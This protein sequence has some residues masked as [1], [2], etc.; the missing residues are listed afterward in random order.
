MALSCDG[1]VG[2]K[3]RIGTISFDRHGKPIPTENKPKAIFARLFKVDSSSKQAQRKQLAHKGKMI[4]MV[5]ENAND[6]KRQLGKSDKEKLEEYMNSISDIEDRVNRADKWLDIP[7]K[8]VNTDHIK[9]DVDP[10][11]AP[12]EYYRTMYDLIALAFE[13]DVTRA[14]TFMM[15][16]EDG[17]GI[18]DAF[19]T[20]SQGLNGHHKLSHSAKEKDGY[21]KWSM[22][23]QF[24]ANQVAYFANRLNKIK[25]SNGTVLDNTIVFFGSGC[26]TTHAANN[27]PLL[28]C[29]GN[30]MGFKHGEHRKLDKVRLSNL[31]LTQLKAMG[32]EIDSFADST[33]VISGL[34]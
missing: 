11:K 8:K 4:D 21:K 34:I 27:Y 24:V 22:H 23:D 26:S 32:I 33:G 12:E 6:L 17:M 2:F 18:A 19:S 5:M 31:Y 28:M 30:N 9:L 29:G 20:I 3:S 10:Q 14:A 13:T 25:D 16:R 7:L 1:G 15:S